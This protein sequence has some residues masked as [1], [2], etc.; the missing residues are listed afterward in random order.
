[1]SVKQTQAGE[2]FQFPLKI[3]FMVADQPIVSEQDI[4]EKE[5]VV[6]APLPGRPTM[7]CIDPDQTLLAE[8]EETKGRGL[9]LEQLAKADVAGRVRAAQYLGK[10]KLPADREALAKALEAEKFWG[11]QAETLRT[12][13]LTGLGDSQDLSA[14][15]TLAEWTKRGK[16]RVCRSSAIQALARLARTA[17]PNEEQQKRIAQTL[18]ACLDEQ[19]LVLLFSAV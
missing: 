13:A 14:F 9:W 19:S 7:V 15:D 5:Q 18:S 12:A 1:V 10:S 6:Y 16:P 11:V 2:A 8:I 4:T 17:N 3:L